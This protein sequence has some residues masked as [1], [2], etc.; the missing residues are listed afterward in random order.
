MFNFGINLFL[1]FS[2]HFLFFILVDEITKNE[3]RMSDFLYD[4]LRLQ[5]KRSKMKMENI[6]KETNYY[7]IFLFFVTFVN[8]N[9][10]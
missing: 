1:S 3:N 9:E 7:V 5:G 6:K 4:V 10:K 2:S 8:Q